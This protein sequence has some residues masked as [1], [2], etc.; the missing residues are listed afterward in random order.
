VITVVQ[1]ILVL[2]LTLLALFVVMLGRREANQERE[3]AQRDAAAIRE[4]SRT[5]HLE[6]KRREERIALREREIAE[7]QRSLGTYQRTLDERAAALA[8]TERKLEGEKGMLR[9]T[10]DAALAEIAG[11]DSVEARKR[12]TERLT[13]EAEADAA[14]AVRRI[15]KR[16][17]AEAAIRGR[18]ILVTAMQRQAA[19]SSAQQSVTRIELPSEEMKGRLIGREGRNIRTFEAITGVSMILEDGVDSVLLSAFDV[20]RREIAE[21]TLRALVADGRIQPPRIEAAYAAAV[22]SGPERAVAAGLDA[23]EQAKVGGLSPEM[24]ETLGRLRL[25]TSYGQNVLAH[26]V[27]CAGLAAAIAVEIGADPETARRA[28]FL[29]DLGKASAGEREG[30]HAAVGAELAAAAGETDAVV[31]AIAAH[32][33]EVPMESIEA[34]IVQIADGLSASRPGARRED[35]DGYV[36]RMASLEAMVRGIPG[37]SDVMAMQAGREVRVVV[38]PEHVGD[39]ELPELARTIAQRINENS[40]LS[41][42]VKVTVIR[43]LRAEAVAG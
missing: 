4:E 43:E 38:S 35:F 37:V 9:E 27:E 5:L 1:I 41:G 22:A 26:L 15:E 33:D 23:A 21:V 8:K 30:T 28:A 16:I 11:L 17:E 25:R 29:H 3:S 6:T 18:E 2:G 39:A 10:Q 32:H 7:D 42:E 34:V 19:E 13:T 36:E 31:N 12:L 40:K 14:G 24:I 20:E